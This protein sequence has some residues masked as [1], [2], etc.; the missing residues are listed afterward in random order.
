MVLSDDE[1]NRL[2]MKAWASDEDWAWDIHRSL[3][4]HAFAGLEFEQNPTL[5]NQRKIHET[6]TVVDRCLERAKAL[7]TPSS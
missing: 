2:F 3:V 5:A 7:E 6:G 4:D 1:K